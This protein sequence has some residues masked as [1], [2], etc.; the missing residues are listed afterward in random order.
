MYFTKL[1]R[2][3]LKGRI[4]REKD[5]ETGEGETP[6]EKG[7]VDGSKKDEET[8]EAEAEIT[9]DG[10]AVRQMTIRTTI[11]ESDPKGQFEVYIDADGTTEDWFNA[12]SGPSTEETAGAGAGKGEGSEKKQESNE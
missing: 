1:Q 10:Q 12:L 2:K 9:E 7:N 5:E 11:S 4:E 6:E 3:R 8:E